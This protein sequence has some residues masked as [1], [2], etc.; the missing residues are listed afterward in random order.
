MSL[1]LFTILPHW[2][3]LVTL[4]PNW[5]YI[6]LGHYHCFTRVEDNAC[7]CGST[8]RFSFSEAGEIKGYAMD[9]TFRPRVILNQISWV[10]QGKTFFERISGTA[11][12]NLNKDAKGFE[13]ACQYLGG[14]LHDH[15][16]HRQAESKKAPFS[17]LV[18]TRPA[19]QC[20]EH[21][22]KGLLHEPTDVPEFKLRNRF[23][24][25]AEVIRHKM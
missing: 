12:S 3:V 6:A 20:Y 9:R 22:A 11:G 24:R 23:V 8:E 18:P 14:V 15:E 2:H 1:Q 19:A 17:K 10:E 7:Y 4:K 25:F 5:D 21:L 13:I 16:Y